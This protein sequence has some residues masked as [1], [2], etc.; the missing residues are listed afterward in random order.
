[1][2]AGPGLDATVREILSTDLGL[3]AALVDRELDGERVAGLAAVP[4]SGWLGLELAS[5]AAADG[6]RLIDAGL[7]ELGDPVD[8]VALDRLAVDYADIFL[9]YAFQASPNE[10]VWLDKE[11]L[12]RQGPMFEIRKWYAHYGLAAE[13]WS[14]R[15]EDFVG[16]QLAFLAHLFAAEAPHAPA[17]AARFLDEHP[18]RWVGDFALRVTGRSGSPFYGGLVLVIAAYLDELRDY[19][20]EALDLPR[21]EPVVE[22]AQEENTTD[23]PATYFPGAGPS[24]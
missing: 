17:D 7:A 3:L 23:E 12:E 20:A 1:M 8:P 24:W 13:D 21:P 2:T 14:R 16:L 11:N 4:A 15:T 9:N 18:L 6:F 19:L 5:E 22:E 10:S